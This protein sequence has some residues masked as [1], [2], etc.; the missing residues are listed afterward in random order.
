MP[1]LPKETIKALTDTV[2]SQAVFFL[3]DADEFYPFGSV[4]D[5]DQKIKPVG[6]YFGEEYPDSTD[7]L[8]R[9]EDAIK[10][11]ITKKDYLSAAIGLDV[12]I[13]TKIENRIE[14]RTALELRL[15]NNDTYTTS[16]FLYFKKDGK[17]TLEPLEKKD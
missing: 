10:E 14:K 13:N 1:D 8:N 9:L 2:L 17:Y 12:Y 3:N 16:Y 7:V 11:G 5:K 15:Y 4:I 6:I